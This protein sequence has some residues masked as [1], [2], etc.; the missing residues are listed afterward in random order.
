MKL[1]NQRYIKTVLGTYDRLLDTKNHIYYVNLDE[2][3]ENA[4]VKM[5]NRKRELVSDNY[6]AY[7][8]FM[9]DIEDTSCHTWMSDK[10]KQHI[11]Y[12]KTC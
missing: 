1:S 12:K 7:Q 9:D 8:S 10:L 3:D 5:F 11:A 4:C 6:F 2:C